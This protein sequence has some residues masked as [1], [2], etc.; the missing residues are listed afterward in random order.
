M[1]NLGSLASQAKPLATNL[2]A[3]LRSLKYEG[4]INRFLD[5]VFYLA[6]SANGYDQY[7]H[8]VRTRLVL[9]SCT[10]YATQN[11]LSCTA[12]FRKDFGG[13]TTP[14]LPTS[15]GTPSATSTA[16]QGAARR[17]RGRGAG[18]RRAGGQPHDQAA[19]GA[20]AR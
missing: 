5:V 12:N 2:S 19:R 8:Y 3:L 15:G 9:T 6:G 4:G 18:D 1:Q 7:G 20:A 13:V 10:T 16:V 11:Q 14:A 17:S